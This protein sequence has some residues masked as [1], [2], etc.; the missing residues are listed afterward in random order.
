MGRLTTKRPWEEACKDMK[1]ELGYSHI[2]KRLHDIEDIL[3][4]EYDLELL[5]KL[6][7]EY[8]QRSTQQ[9]S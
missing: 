8:K 3:G 2:W 9:N 5:N 1:E 4:D 6:V 7:Q